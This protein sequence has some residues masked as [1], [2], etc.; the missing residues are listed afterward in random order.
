MQWVS[1]VVRGAGGRLQVKVETDAGGAV[2][3]DIGALR[4]DTSRGGGVRRRGLIQLAGL[5]SKCAG[6]YLKGLGLNAEAVAGQPVYETDMQGT[7]WC[8]PSQALVMMVFGTRKLLRERL[9]TPSTPSSFISE[10]AIAQTYNPALRARLRWMNDSPSAVRAWASIYRNAIEG[11]L[12]MSMPEATIEVS[13][14]GREVDGVYLV[15]HARLLSLQALDIPAHAQQATRPSTPD[16]PSAAGN[17]FRT[18]VRIDGE[19]R[20]HGWTSL[21][22]LSDAQWAGIQPHVAADDQARRGARRRHD[23]RLVTETLLTKL[24]GQLIWAEV[25]GDRLLVAAASNLFQKLRH[26]RTLEA[27]IRAASTSHALE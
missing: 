19:P 5:T 1:R 11:R 15:T 14:Q 22:R 18:T 4:T 20:L 21:S 23:P 10:L 17:G 26:Q 13:A 27:V 24:A 7:L 3:K 25:P 12:E 9:L 16:Q 8:I 6:R 2:I